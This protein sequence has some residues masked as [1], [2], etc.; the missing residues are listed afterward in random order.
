MA[1]PNCLKNKKTVSFCCGTIHS[2]KFTQSFKTYSRSDSKI[3]GKKERVKMKIRIF[4]Q[5]TVCP[6]L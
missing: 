4:T 5:Y 1:H 6:L 3:G 2:S